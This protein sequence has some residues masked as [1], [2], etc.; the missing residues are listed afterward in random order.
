MANPLTFVRPFRPHQIRSILLVQSGPM[1]LMLRV[2][3][4]L[5]SIAPGCEITAVVREDHREAARTGGFDHVIV[6]RWE[7]RLEVVRTLRGRRFDTVAV[8]MSH[9]GSDYLRVLP[10]L[11]RTRSILAFNDNLDSFPVHVARAGTLVLHVSGQRSA[12][13]LV[14]WAVSRTVLAI[15]ATAV[16][17]AAVLRIEIRAAW[18]RAR[19]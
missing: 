15:V 14:R 17:V 3:E 16:L 10:Y 9:H 8:L 19:A 18:R 6:V 5:R 4:R 1:A 13:G 11:L 7:D 2:G 12:G